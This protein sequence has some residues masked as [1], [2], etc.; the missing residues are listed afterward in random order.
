MGTDV[1]RWKDAGLCVVNTITG[2]A[3]LRTA[4]NIYVCRPPWDLVSDGY[5]PMRYRAWVYGMGIDMVGEALN[6]SGDAS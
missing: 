1:V 4:G 2:Y 5:P 3:G 6:A